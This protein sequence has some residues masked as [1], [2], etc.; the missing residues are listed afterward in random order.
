M[1]P[2][3][4]SNLVH[5]QFFADA[6]PN[7]S[8]GLL[9]CFPLPSAPRELTARVT[10]LY[11]EFAAELSNFNLLFLLSGATCATRSP[12]PLKQ[13]I[14]ALSSSVQNVFGS[15]QL[16]SML[17]PPPPKALYSFGRLTE[18]NFHRVIRCV[19]HYNQGNTLS[20][21]KNAAMTQYLC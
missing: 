4:T 13:G 2:G 9:P 5:I 21:L 12:F 19:I 8:W 7:Q 3:K 20:C 14:P 18:Q 15:L 6:L 16:Y 17:L 1:S 10:N 11:P